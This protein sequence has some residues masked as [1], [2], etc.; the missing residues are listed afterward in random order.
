MNE[1]TRRVIL[2]LDDFRVR[3]LSR[4]GCMAKGLAGGS[5]AGNVVRAHVVSKAST[6]KPI[7]QNGHLLSYDDRFDFTQ[8]PYVWFGFSEVGVGQATTF[9]GFCARHDRELFSC[10]ENEGFDARPDQCFALAYRAVAHEVHSR[11]GSNRFLEGIAQQVPARHAANVRDLAASMLRRHQ[12]ARDGIL[13]TAAGLSVL[14]PSGVAGGVEHLVIG[15]DGVLP[16]AFGGAF[17]PMWDFDDNQFQFMG[18]NEAAAGHLALNTATAAGRSHVILSW[19]TEA[20]PRLRALLCQVEEMPL[21]TAG[22]AVLEMAMEGVGTLV[23][24]PSWM[25]SLDPQAMAALERLL[26]HGKTYAPGPTPWIGLRHCGG[27]P[28]ATGRQLVR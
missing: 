19:L 13:L 26:I 12:S 27:V 22:H 21:A 24:S 7:A 15:Y 20:E 16:F 5:C 11:A 2:R 8:T 1:E 14:L 17:A 18:A 23:F 25:K 28:T 9:H 3:S 4:K 10:V 6:L